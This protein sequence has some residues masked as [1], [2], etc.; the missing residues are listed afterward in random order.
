MKKQVLPILMIPVL[1][2]AFA[3]QKQ[4]QE[5]AIEPAADVEADIAAIKTLIE[6]WVQL[7]N[8]EDFDRLMSVF[9]AEDPVLMAPNARARK[10][11]DAILLAYQKDSESNIE[12]V[13]SSVAEAVRVSGNMAA[14][15]GVDTGTTTP[16]SGGEPIKYIVNWLMVFERQ[17]DGGWKCLYEMWNENPLPETTEKSDRTNGHILA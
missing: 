12:H 13:D 15:W 16:R 7:Y 2:F 11:K 5:A 9:Y 8:A 3:C 10:G 14:A 6:Q 1:C 4:G 17:P